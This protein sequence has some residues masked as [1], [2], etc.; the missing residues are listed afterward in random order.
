MSKTHVIHLQTINFITLIVTKII[1]SC[2]LQAVVNGLKKLGHKMKR[3]KDRGSVVC[4]VARQNN[5]VYANADYRKGGEVYG[6]D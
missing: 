2:I 6:I 3:Y 5:I 4:A 1:S